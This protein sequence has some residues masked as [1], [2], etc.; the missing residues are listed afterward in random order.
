MAKATFLR[1]FHHD[2]KFSSGWREWEH[3]QPP[4]TIFTI[5]YKVAV[6]APAESADTLPLFHLYPF[7]YSVLQSLPSCPAV[8]SLSPYL[9]LIDPTLYSLTGSFLS[10]LGSVSL[11]ASLRRRRTSRRAAI[12]SSVARPEAEFL[13]V[14]GT[15]V[16][17]VFITVTSTNRFYS[18]PHLS[19][20]GLKLV[21]DVET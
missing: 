13:D 1:T 16:F 2:G 7:V 5:T 17:T 9:V 12:S 18:P 3:A 15:K 14:I 21:F 11:R 20:C 6:Y 19:K 4:F 10:G 8:C